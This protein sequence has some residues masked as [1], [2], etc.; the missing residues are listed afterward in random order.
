[1]AEA[2]ASQSNSHI[3]ALGRAG[4]VFMWAIDTGGH[5]P[6]ATPEGAAEQIV[7]M[8]LREVSE[9]DPDEDNRAAATTLL[10]QF[11]ERRRG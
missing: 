10:E 2:K 6:D 3:G 1:M 5:N 7:A 8:Y 9:H 11:P 4:N